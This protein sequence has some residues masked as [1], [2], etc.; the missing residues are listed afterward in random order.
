MV[1]KIVVL[2]RRP[3]GPQSAIR[4]GY[5]NQVFQGC[6]LCGLPVPSYYDLATTAV[7][8]LGTGSSPTIW[9]R[10]LTTVAVGISTQ[11]SCL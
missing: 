1:L 3:V 10:G 6:L 8:I 5:E 7:G 2:G 9:L 4:Y 11:G